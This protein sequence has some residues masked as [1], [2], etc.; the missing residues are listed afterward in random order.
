MW[1]LEN[2]C[3][4]LAKTFG[5]E[6]VNFQGCPT[7]CPST[8]TSTPS[9][10]AN[11]SANFGVSSQKCEF[12]LIVCPCKNNCIC[13]SANYA[14]SSQPCDSLCTF[15][16]LNVCPLGNFFCKLRSFL[17]EMW[18]L[19]CVLFQKIIVFVPFEIILQTSRFPL[20]NVSV[21]LV[22]PSKINCNCPLEK[23]SAKHAVSSQKCEFLLRVSLQK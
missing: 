22:C 15:A 18:V 10:S 12:L 1:H 23:F 8:G 3:K 19:L 4:L 7:S 11:F 13:L 20:R 17:S 9:H 2:L 21:Y 16:K 5:S 14:V 6:I